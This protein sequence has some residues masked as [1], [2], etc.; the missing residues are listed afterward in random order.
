MEKLSLAAKNA[1]PKVQTLDED[2]IKAALKEALKKSISAHQGGDQK[3][4]KKTNSE[5]RA[6]R[7]D[8]H[9]LAK[10]QD[11]AQDAL[12]QSYDELIENIQDNSSVLKKL[13]EV[14][15]KNDFKKNWDGF[16]KGVLSQ[17]N[18]VFA[19]GFRVVQ[20]AYGF[21]KEASE[22]KA[23]DSKVLKHVEATLIDKGPQ[24]KNPDKPSAA[25]VQSSIVDK[26][27]VESKQNEKATKAERKPAGEGP[28]VRAMKAVQVA[29]EE[30]TKLL[31][32]IASHLEAPKQPPSAVKESSVGNSN[33]TPPRLTKREKR[34]AELARQSQTDKVHAV[35]NDSKVELIKLA[36]EEFKHLSLLDDIQKD[37][38]VLVRYNEQQLQ[39]A[40]EARTDANKAQ[41]QALDDERESSAKKF[42]Q[43]SKPDSHQA[44]K[45]DAPKSGG[46]LQ[47]MLAEIV[48]EVI[49]NRLLKGG[50][51]LKGLTKAMKFLA[52][53]TLLSGAAS[54]AS[55]GGSA[56]AGFAKAVPGKVASIASS[57]GGVIAKGYSKVKGLFGIGSKVAGEATE[58]AGPISKLLGAGGR[59]LK[60]AK[61]IPV[62]GQI[63]SA[64]MAISDFFS[65][66][67]NASD[68]LDKKEMD[69]TL[70]D[71]ISAGFAKVVGGFVAIVDGLAWLLGFDT[72][73]A[74]QV[75]KKLGKML[76]EFPGKV[77]G[78]FDEFFSDFQDNL[79]L[80][81]LKAA[82]G[83]LSIIPGGDAI[84][85]A[86]GLDDKI[87]A[88]EASKKVAQEERAKDPNYK[89]PSEVWADKASNFLS[90]AK[91]VGVETLSKTGQAIIDPIGTVGDLYSKAKD[92]VSNFFSS[93]KENER[94]IQDAK[95]SAAR[96]GDSKAPVVI[97]AKKTNISQTTINTPQI[98]VRN[99]DDAW[100]T[101]MEYNFPI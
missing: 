83:V 38:A 86:L 51:L 47:N 50:G 98:S 35:E 55:K 100:R 84:S 15:S 88:T 59:L 45:G 61:A 22:S 78:W 18:P 23:A 19:T 33:N 96:S 17:I 11:K 27:K 76:S 68:I 54:L 12:I 66:F 4:I 60:G 24:T 63:I 16:K 48:G 20:S 80:G 49:G 28:F 58:A 37:M 93:S 25:D 92:T 97:D 7:S 95:E 77:V 73:F 87:K 75:T 41:L 44:G 21:V 94:R 34:Q 69:T 101:G 9:N 31:E 70:W 67:T 52:P 79:K 3:E 26:P 13:K 43:V 6:L 36:P 91:D 1:P 99:A 85:S 39:V 40:K 65:G 82:K 53:T 10:G 62:I 89:K 8:V 32:K 56:V 64:V 74:G 90:M 2:K 57:A 81:M 72:D 42:A 71:K 14:Y 29:S 5:L 30:Q 46:F